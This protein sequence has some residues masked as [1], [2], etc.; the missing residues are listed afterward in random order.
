MSIA[1]P[2][3]NITRRALVPSFN[4]QMSTSQGNCSFRSHAG[5]LGKETLKGLLRRVFILNAGLGF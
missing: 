2:N 5:G 4:Y 1:R 3:P